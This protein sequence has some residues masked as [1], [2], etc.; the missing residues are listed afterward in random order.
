MQPRAL[1][2]G[3]SGQDGSYLA[4]FLLNKGYAVWGTSRDAEL[5]SF[6]NLRTLGIFEKIQISSATPSDFRSVV[7][8]IKLAEPDEIYNLSGQSSVGL[9]FNQPMEAM[10]SV[11]TATLNILETIR[12][13]NPH[14]RF[15]N[16]GSSECYGYTG[17]SPANEETPFRP[18]SPYAT[19]K[20]AA[21][22]AVSNY[23][24]AYGLYACS[25]ILFNH[26]SPFRPE[27]FVTQKIVAAAAKAATGEAPGPL[28]LGNLDISRDW[29][30]AEEYVDVIWRMLQT[31]NPKDYVVATGHTSSLRD[32]ASEAFAAFELDWRDHVEHDPHLKRPAD[33]V[34]SAAD[35]SLALKELGWK[36]QT[37]MPEVVRKMVLAR[38][39]E[40][41]A[42]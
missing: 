15:Y 5:S 31:E 8:I 39:G 28:R 35:P 17:S 21:H 22:W 32:F 42:G 13:L 3:I 9:S 26:E 10:E 38:R 12:F 36:A 4:Q 29:G 20:A 1:I 24:D 6:R 25:G 30:W 40:I 33:I 2:F 11:V 16:A 34:Y 19:A 37:L 27:R 23:R 14:I 7:Q 18:R 41:C